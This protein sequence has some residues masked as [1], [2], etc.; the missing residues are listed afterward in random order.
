MEYAMAPPAPPPA[1]VDKDLRRNRLASSGFWIRVFDSVADEE[2]HGF[3]DGDG[4][5]EAG[6]R[7]RWAGVEFSFGDVPEDSNVVGDFLDAVFF[8]EEERLYA[9]MTMKG[10]RRRMKVKMKIKRTSENRT[11]PCEREKAKVCV[12]E[13]GCEIGIIGRRFSMWGVWL[14]K[15]KRMKK[16]GNLGKNVAKNVSMSYI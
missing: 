14:R 3:V 15:K 12:V 16:K 11:W 5:V 10:R 13:I 6:E 9:E 7:L 1:A 8:G 2:E 4:D